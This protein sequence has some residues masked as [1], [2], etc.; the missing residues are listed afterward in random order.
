MSEIRL[1][2]RHV[3][4]ALRKQNLPDTFLIGRY[5]FSPYMACSHGCTYCDGRAERYYVEGDFER[6]I[7]VRR[8]LTECLLAELPKLRE[9]ATIVVGSGISDAYQPPERDEHLMRKAAEV[10]SNFEFPVTILTKSSL[11]LRDIDLWG[12]VNRR[13]GFHLYMSVG[14]ARDDL[15]KIFEP[16][17]SSVEDRLA[18]LAAYQDAGCHVGIVA[19]PLLPFIGDTE[20]NVR[21]LLEMAKDI[22]VDFFMPGGLTLRPGRQKAFFM[23]VLQTHFPDL[24]DRYREIYGNELVSGRCVYHYRTESYENASRL[25]AEYGFPEEIPHHAYRNRLPLYDEM[26]VL[27]NHMVVLYERQGIDVRRLKRAAGGY[28]RWL[29]ERKRVF[30]RHR[31]MT[32]AGLED[33]LRSHLQSGL[34]PEM[35]PNPKLLHFM[36][37]VILERRTF[38]YCKLRLADTD[39]LQITEP[40]PD[41]ADAPDGF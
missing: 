21:C 22:G 28:G 26:H 20:E 16:G 39:S 13:G 8:N 5:S 11:I 32:Q 30:N 24:V 3:K 1:H 36:R 15:R 12:K 9:R 10:L 4:K 27:L 37:R 35:P 40:R 19:L 29:G 7:V 41:G 25:V 18:A 31:T 23:D 33:E 34:P 6:D 2:E 14:F 38:D 17:A